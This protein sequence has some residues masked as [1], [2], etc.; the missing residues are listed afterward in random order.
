MAKLQTIST[1]CTGW[2]S[3]ALS[4]LNTRLWMEES[5]AI[6]KNKR[7]TNLFIPNKKFM[8]MR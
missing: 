2:S 1:D 4:T 7:K 5:S 6:Y 8:V 3:G